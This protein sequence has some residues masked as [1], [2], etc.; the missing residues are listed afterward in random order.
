MTPLQNSN[1]QS[2]RQPVPFGTFDL[3]VVL[4]TILIEYIY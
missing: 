3:G 2:A 4:V 1:Q